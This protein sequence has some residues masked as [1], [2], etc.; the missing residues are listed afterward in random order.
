MDHT[1]T[2][3][4][5]L[6]IEPHVRTYPDPI[7]INQGERVSA[8]ERDH[9]G[10]RDGDWIWCSNAAGKSGWVPEQFLAIDGE[11]ATTLVDCDTIEMTVDVGE[12][13]TGGEPVNGWV[14]CEN[15]EEETGWVPLTCVQ[16]AE[17]EPE[18]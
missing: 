15:E 1:R 11:E 10:D 3:R 9:S 8:G 14:W 5:L 13:L 17:P 7:S 16:A 18:A 12:R 4:P 2:T 6:V